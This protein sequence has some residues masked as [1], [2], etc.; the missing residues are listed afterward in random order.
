MVEADTALGHHLFVNVEFAIEPTTLLHVHDRSAIICRYG[1]YTCQLLG[2][3]VP[4]CDKVFSLSN[5]EPDALDLASASLLPCR[6][7]MMAPWLSASPLIPFLQSAF[8]CP[9]SMPALPEKPIAFP[10]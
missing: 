5:A 1:N 8:A 6:P 10:P 7:L 9:V 3:V 4:R 2:S